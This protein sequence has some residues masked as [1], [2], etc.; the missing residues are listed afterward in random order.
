MR[1]SKGQKYAANLF[2]GGLAADIDPEMLEPKT[3]AVIE[4]HCMQVSSIAKNMLQTIR[5]DKG[6]VSRTPIAGITL[7]GG[8]WLKG[9]IVAFYRDSI[10]N[11][12]YIY[13][14]NLLIG[15]HADYPQNYLDIDSNDETTEM[16]I[17]DNTVCP[18]VLN[19]QDMLDSRV[20]GIK[21]FG[22]YVRKLYEVNKPIQL[23]QP[24]FLGLEDIGPGGGLKTGSYAYQM[25]YSSKYGEDTPWGPITPYIPIPERAVLNSTDMEERFPGLQ[26]W[27]GDASLEPTRYGIRLKLRIANLSGFDFIKIKRYSNKTN[28]PVSYTPAPEFT[29]MTV[30]ANGERIDIVKNPYGIIEFVDT[31]MLEWAIL[32]DSVQVTYSTIKTSRTIRYVDRRIVLGGVEYMP[33]IV[34]DQDIFL[35]ESGATRIAFPVVKPLAP[36]G[37]SDIMNQVYNKSLRLGEKYGWGIKLRDDQGDTLYTIPVKF[38]Q[39]PKND[40]TNFQL[41]NRRDALPLGVKR[42]DTIIL[43]GTI[44]Q[45]DITCNEVTR[46]VVFHKTLTLTAQE[47]VVNHAAAYLSGGV[48]VTS[49][50]NTIIFTSTTEGVDFTG[51]TTIVTTSDAG[52]TFG[53]TVLSTPASAGTRHGIDVY[54]QGSSGFIEITCGGITRSQVFSSDLE[55]TARNFADNY[56]YVY[57]SQLGVTVGYFAGDYGTGIS[58]MGPADGTAI[59]VT[60]GGD[61]AAAQVNIPQGN[62]GGHVSTIT[63]G[64]EGQVQQSLITLTGSVGQ[65]DISCGGVTRTITARG[66]RDQTVLGFTSDAANI[67]AYAAVDIT[68]GHSNSPEGYRV[69][70]GG[71]NKTVTFTPTIVTKATGNITGTL[72]NPKIQ[73]YV[74]SIHQTDKVFIKDDQAG[75]ADITCQGV[76]RT[77]NSLGI[78]GAEEACRIFV[79]NYATT[80]A[81]VGINIGHHPDGVIFYGPETGTAITTTAG[82]SVFDHIETLV[83]PVP[84]VPQIDGITLTGNSG[85]ALITC[86]GLTRQI[87]FRDDLATT[88]QDF[89]DL[90]S[91]DYL[92]HSITLGTDGVDTVTFA[93]DLTIYDF[94]TSIA[95][96]DS[97]LS[98]IVSLMTANTAPVVEVKDLAINGDSGGIYVTIQGLQNTMSFNSDYQTTV[99]SFVTA[100]SAAYAALGVTLSASDN[101]GGWWSLRMTGPASGVGVS[102]SWAPYFAIV[103][104]PNQSMANVIAVSQEDQITLTGDGGNVLIVCNTLQRPL[105]Y[106]VSLNATASKFVADYKADYAVAPYYVDVR[107]IGEY[108]TFASLQAGGSFMGATTITPAV[109]NLTGTVEYTRANDTSGGEL[110]VMSS[111]LEDSTVLSYNAADVQYVYDPVKAGTKAK[112]DSNRVINIVSR[113]CDDTTSH[114]PE[115]YPY[116]ILNPIGRGVAAKN[117]NYED[118][119]N[120]NVMSCDGNLAFPAAGHDISGVPRYGNQFSTVGMRI[121]GIDV[122]KLPSTVKSFSV[123]RTPPAGRVVCQGIAMYSLIPQPD[124][125]IVDTLAKHLNKVWF[126]SPE[127]DP[128][129]GDKG[130]LYD[131]IKRT[132]SAF[133]IQLVA[134]CGFFTDV[135]GSV[136]RWGDSGY[137]NSY[138]NQDM[139]S[140]VI[141]GAGQNAKAMNPSDAA[142][143][144]GRDD[145]ITFGRWRNVSNQASLPA[146]LIFDIDMAVD[147]DHGKNSR[148]SYLELE[149]SADI[150][151]NSSIDSAAGTDDKSKD[152]HE[153]WYIVN[154]IQNKDVANNNINI[155][156]DIGHSIRLES[157]V[158]ISNGESTQTFPLADERREDVYSNANTAIGYRYLWVDGLPWL[159]SNNIVGM[160]GYLASLEADGSFTPTG[161]LE[162]YGV[163]TLTAENVITFDKVLP[164]SGDP[165]VPARGTE[166]VVRYNSNSPIEVFLG[167]TYVA[168]A[169]FF[170]IDT[171]KNVYKE[172]VLDVE[173]DFRMYAAMPFK[174]FRFKNTYHQAVN[175]AKIG[176]DN[177]YDHRAIWTDIESN[178]GDQFIQRVRQ[179]LIYFPCESTINLPLLYK[180]FYPNKLYAPRPAIFEDK[181]DDETVDEYLRRMK[182]YTQYNDDFPDEYKNWR[183]GGLSCPTTINYDYQKALPGKSFTEPKSGIN[184]ILDYPKRVHWSTQNAPGFSANRLFVPTNVYDLKNDRASHISI[185]YDVFSDRGNN[186]Y[187]ITDRG[188]GLLLM[189]KNMITTAD[190]NNLSI[191]AQESTLIK[192]ELW[193]SDSIGCPEHYWR[194]KCE[195]SVKMP[196][197]VVVPVLIFP[198]YRDIAMLSNNSFMYMSD[199]NRAEIST[200]LESMVSASKMFSVIDESENKLWIT[201]DDKTLGFNFDIN[202]WDVKIKGARYQKSVYCKYLEGST[203]RNIIAHYLND[204]FDFG[205]TLSHKVSNRVSAVGGAPY[206]VFS[207]TPGLGGV[208]EFYDMFL[209]CS[210]RPSSIQLSLS[211]TFSDSITITGDRIKTYDGGW[212]YVQAFAKSPASKVFKGKTLFVKVSFADFLQPYSIKLVKTG[213]KEVVG[214]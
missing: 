164:V 72:N 115:R 7:I 37:Y 113:R 161:G 77:L 50:Q 147:V 81:A 52:N 179:W 76:T 203:D 174:T 116:G 199:N 75:Y 122:S 20:A 43:S 89:I 23:N 163:C 90:Y 145:Y 183:Y 28:M 82:G 112:A 17:T 157:I 31:N 95:H 39:E 190:G 36:G 44:G 150:Y 160:A 61:L 91:A 33:K 186:L 88:I 98:G 137:S 187:V 169:S 127:I 25:C 47:F 191:L 105:T 41:P 117:K 65:A 210:H 10:T 27:G 69:Y 207:V 206:V 129:I 71:K 87:S 111:P 58:F 146:D 166:V 107:A 124:G 15:Q 133:Q 148:A 123:V 70:F 189:D 119:L 26:V 19:L 29:I 162:C 51:D 110:S 66:T 194:A 185:L 138:V 108:L 144:I 62:M 59:E 126:F 159:D 34:V 152:F 68:L 175:P 35:A 24:I 197:N 49:Y 32:D 142:G 106:G 208:Y 100:F 18:I 104:S 96:T 154:I 54:L 214:G 8:L 92:I 158:G 79:Q 22:G 53:G 40:F 12:T 171:Y 118:L 114:T 55:T 177:I 67:A 38:G 5:G 97:D 78:G 4:S 178:N 156:N 46:A 85:S 80:Y 200:A 48:V 56:G 94:D 155:Y 149:L 6:Y 165:V 136:G 45:A 141:C 209:S 182:I 21:Y 125:T 11:L 84:G 63:P 14:N 140:S 135:Y 134:P 153:P 2:F 198:N 132:P 99:E 42:V 181:L 205:L 121:G 1:S 101:G 64:N 9:Y 128:A 211:K 176:L 130:T 212:Y 139:V 184:E 173:D 202:N 16:F 57:S 86:A 195:G 168:N 73:D 143:T 3:G 120:N 103:S 204:V 193:L 131:N 60:V 188:S 102:A 151:V 93:G 213:Y 201:L 172:P 180:D 74:P 30:D 109:N 83:D 170:A 192:G 196:N 13:A 167:D